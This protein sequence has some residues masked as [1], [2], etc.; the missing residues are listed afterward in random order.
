MQSQGNNV[1]N[2]V[3]DRRSVAAGRD[4]NVGDGNRVAL[5][6][7]HEHNTEIREDEPE[8]KAP[9]H[10][11]GLILCPECK[12]R[13][14]ARS[15]IACTRCGYAHREVMMERERRWLLEAKRERAKLHFYGAL[16]FLCGMFLGLFAWHLLGLQ[17]FAF[18]VL[19]GILGFVFL[20]QLE[21]K[22]QEWR[23]R[24]R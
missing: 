10:A 7:Y 6:D 9:P 16:S 5:G 3:A 23:D 24:G 2:I 12:R 11:S 17:L 15:A 1:R 13:H 21:L 20:P 22:I 19:S 18:A 8:W 14:L 4:V